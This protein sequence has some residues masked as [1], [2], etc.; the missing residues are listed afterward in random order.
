MK[1]KRDLFSDKEWIIMKA[2]WQKQKITVKEVW[3]QIYP[4][5]EKAYTTVQTYMDRLVEKGVLKK[6]K[7]G[8]VNF[9]QAR[10]SEE[11]A[12]DKATEN[13]VSRAFNGSFGLL[14]AFLIDSQRLDP[15]DLERIKQMLE[16]KGSET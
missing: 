9:Y 3:Q 6:E 14:A 5:Q 1:K 16:K 4:H 11:K 8:L 2:V 10:I 13:L 12:L 15:S 7:V